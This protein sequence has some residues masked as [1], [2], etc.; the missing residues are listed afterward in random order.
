MGERYTNGG[1]LPPGE[2]RFDTE[3]GWCEKH[4]KR[5]SGFYERA[6]VLRDGVIRCESWFVC[7]EGE[8]IDGQ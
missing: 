6:Q 2:F 1:V 3:S 8:P 7:T 5:C 4:Q